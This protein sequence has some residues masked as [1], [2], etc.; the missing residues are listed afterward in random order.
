VV[1]RDAARNGAGGWGV[2]HGAPGESDSYDDSS[3][4]NDISARAAAPDLQLTLALIMRLRDVAASAKS[5]LI[6]EVGDL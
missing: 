4:V 3:H 6:I 5:V 2:H 1:S